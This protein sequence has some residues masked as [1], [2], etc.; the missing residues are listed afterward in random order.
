MG[1]VREEEAGGEGSGPR[2]EKADNGQGQT[3][4]PIVAPAIQKAFPKT[5]YQRY[6]YFFS[7]SRPSPLSLS[8]YIRTRK[9]FFWGFFW[10][11]VSKTFP[12]NGF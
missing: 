4:E 12:V 3:R 10:D 6:Y 5:L 1:P 11:A 9:P 7:I 8:P 2:G